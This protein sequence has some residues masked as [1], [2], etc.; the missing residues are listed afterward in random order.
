M[1]Q[2]R[3]I[4]PLSAARLASVGIKDVTDLEE[5]GSVT[6]FRRIKERFP[7]ETSLNLLYALEG[8]LLDLPWDDLPTGVKEELRTAVG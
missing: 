6:A 8:A 3:N 1:E 2:L 4:G 7:A 5:M